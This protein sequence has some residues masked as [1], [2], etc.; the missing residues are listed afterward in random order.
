VI[1]YFLAY[2]ENGRPPQIPA[3]ADLTFDVELIDVQNGTPGG[4]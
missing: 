2:G 1:P 3:K 4:F